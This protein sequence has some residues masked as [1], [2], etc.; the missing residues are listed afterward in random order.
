MDVG[1]GDGARG[2]GMRD[3]DGGEGEVRIPVRVG[4]LHDL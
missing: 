1:C 3:G 4:A 2:G